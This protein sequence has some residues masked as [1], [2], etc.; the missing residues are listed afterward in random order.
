[1]GRPAMKLFWR[2]GGGGGLE[3]VFGRPNLALDSAFVH[4]RKQLQTIKTNRIKH[5]QKAKRA[6]GFEGQMATMLESQ[7]VTIDTTAIK[8]AEKNKF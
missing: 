7:I 4:Q 6:A 8:W 3:I 2:R 1:M 5:K